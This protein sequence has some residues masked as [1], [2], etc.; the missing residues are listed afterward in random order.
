MRIDVSTMNLD[1]VNE[2]A[3]LIEKSFPEASVMI[4]EKN[5]KISI[6][7]VNKKLES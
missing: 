6:K 5:D 4:R 1:K 7:I 2:L 3:K